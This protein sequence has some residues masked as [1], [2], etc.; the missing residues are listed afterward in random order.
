MM[1]IN[2][3]KRENIIMFQDQKFKVN[4]FIDKQNDFKS[5]RYFEKI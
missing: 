3:Q 4:I 2:F 1:I 5:S